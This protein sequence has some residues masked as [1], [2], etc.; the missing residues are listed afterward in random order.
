MKN[1][2]KWPIVILLILVAGCAVAYSQGF[3]IADIFLSSDDDSALQIAKFAFPKKI[4]SYDLYDS[5]IDIESQCTDMAEGRFCTRYARSAYREDVSKKVVYVFLIK[6]TEGKDIYREYLKKRVQP[7]A[8]NSQI[9]RL[10]DKND[11]ALGW[12]INGNIFD[13][14]F[15]TEG[16]VNHDSNGESIEYIIPGG[17]DPVT[18][19]FLDQFIP[20]N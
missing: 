6:I 17:K 9:F 13:I 20:S 15:I 4:D 19:Y 8:S 1:I 18:S 11:H 16:T 3:N 10:S 12:F 2:F 7:E 5:S 14:V